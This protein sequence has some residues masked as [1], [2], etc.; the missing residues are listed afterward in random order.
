MSLA[1]FQQLKELGPGH[2][3]VLVEI[4]GIDSHLVHE[5]CHLNGCLR[6]KMYVRNYRDHYAFG[7][8]TLAYFPDVRHILQPGHC[9]AYHLG[10]GSDHP[11]ALRQST[12]NIIR[13]GV[14][15]G[16]D[17]NGASP[18]DNKAPGAYIHFFCN[19]SHLPYTVS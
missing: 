4:A 3:M 17:N 14:A 6:R 7:A 13:M 9:D 19:E 12:F 1:H 8:K 15:H 16:L 11:A 2:L 18:S 10:S 5:A